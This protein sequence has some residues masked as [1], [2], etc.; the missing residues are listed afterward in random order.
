MLFTSITVHHV[1]CNVQCY[2]TMMD[3]NN[4]LFIFFRNSLKIC[5]RL[6]GSLTNCTNS[7]EQQKI[8]I[9]LYAFFK[10][11]AVNTNSLR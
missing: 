6:N 4:H 9:Y 1:F 11:Q 7:Y 8:G 2:I 10:R 3:G 5:I